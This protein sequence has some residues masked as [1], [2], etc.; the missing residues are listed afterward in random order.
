ML[1]SRKKFWARTV[2]EIVIG[3][4]LLT[5]VTL[6]LLTRTGLLSYSD[7]QAVFFTAL[8]PWYPFLFVV[9]DERWMIFPYALTTCFFILH[10]IFVRVRFPRCSNVL[11]KVRPFVFLFIASYLASGWSRLSTSQ[12]SLTTTRVDAGRMMADVSGFPFRF[13]IDEAAYAGSSGYSVFQPLLF[14]A[15][16]IFYLSV[17][18]LI[19]YGWKRYWKK[20]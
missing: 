4:F 20:S 15:N 1:S 14:F 13:S 17:F 2:L 18:L 12:R 3:F 6:F 19:W 5:P 11:R 7:F 9:P 10:T 16:A 8:V